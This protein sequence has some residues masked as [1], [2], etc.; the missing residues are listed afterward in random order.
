MDALVARLARA[1]VTDLAIEQTVTLYHPDGR[2]PQSTG[3]QVLYLKPPGRQ[4]LEQTIDGRREVRLT[5]GDRAWVRRVDGRVQEAATAAPG[6]GRSDLVSPLWRSAGDLLAEWKALGVR[7]EVSHLLQ[8]RGRPVLVVGAG[9]GDRSS[10]AVW[11][12]ELYGVI[13]VTTHER[14]P[15]GLTL[16]DLALS[17]HRPLLDGFH[18]PYRQEL[19]ANGRL[20]LRVVVRTINV[21]RSLPDTL[22]DPEALGQEP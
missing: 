11:L 2:H 17:E 22:F 12:D 9:P 19:F 7:E 3:E 8:L 16:V 10:P 14:L 18:F 13:R 4:R 15:E 1:R 5:V 21:N 6:R 20:L